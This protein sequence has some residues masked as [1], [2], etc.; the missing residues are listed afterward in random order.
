MKPTTF[1]GIDLSQTR[2]IL[3]FAALD[4]KPRLLT[5]QH[6]SLEEILGYIAAQNNA[7]WVGI[8]APA[9]P[10]QGLMKQAE[11]RQQFNLPPNSKTYTNMRRVEYEFLQ[12]GLHIPRTACTPQECPGWM[13][14]GFDLYRQLTSLGFQL[15]PSPESVPL[16]LETQP[17]VAFRALVEQPLYEHRSLEGRLQR[18]LI[19][20]EHGV[21]V[22]DPMEFFEEVTRFKLLR[23]NIPLNMV[24]AQPDLNALAA[25]YTVFLAACKPEKVTRLGAPEEGQIVLPLFEK[26]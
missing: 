15:Y 6:A 25:A 13:Q 23:S 17:E 16:L 18:Q 8:N 5:L 10:N 4:E 3:T 1:I 9:L 21:R 26:N 20:F 24:Q 2:P 14:R 22:P 7:A 12:R 11:V 19:L